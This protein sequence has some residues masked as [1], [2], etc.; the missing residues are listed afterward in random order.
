MD[1][2]G[3][4]AVVEIGDAEQL[5]A[6]G[7]AVVTVTPDVCPEVGEPL[8]VLIVRTRRVL[9]AVESR[10]P[11]ARLPLAG[12]N[13]RGRSLR[14]AGHGRRFDLRTGTERSGRAPRRGCLRT[15][16]VR[17]TD[18]RLFLTLR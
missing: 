9:F 6:S 2:L 3:R 10:C 1:D 18:G 5:L 11:H 13:V 15:F 7:R 12:G 16:A 17:I 4:E 14:C 8:E